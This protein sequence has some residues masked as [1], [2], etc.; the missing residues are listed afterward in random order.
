MPIR[1]AV[2]RGTAGVRPRQHAFS[3]ANVARLTAAQVEAE[4][5]VGVRLSSGFPPT[6]S[7]RL[8]G[9]VF[10]GSDNGFVYSM[11]ARTLRV[12][13]CLPAALAALEFSVGLWSLKK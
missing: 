9:R 4:A 10:V 7:R 1:R 3:A 8:R 13:C 5:Q 12:L 6:R 2:L 11:D